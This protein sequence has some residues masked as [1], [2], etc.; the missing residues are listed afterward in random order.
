M[1]H[2][3]IKGEIYKHKNTGILHTYV[4]YNF[5]VTPH[6]IKWS[7]HHGDFKK[8]TQADILDYLCNEVLYSIISTKKAE[9]DEFIESI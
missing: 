5:Y 3:R 9:L 7:F 4:E 8:A 2:K 6:G 1:K